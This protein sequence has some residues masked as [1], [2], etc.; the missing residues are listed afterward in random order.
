MADKK[1]M[2]LRAPSRGAKQ[3]DP[4]G[5]PEGREGSIQGIAASSVIRHLVLLGAGCRTPRNGK[6]ILTRWVTSLST[7]PPFR[8]EWRRN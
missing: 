8:W 6:I 3:S 7:Y 4:Q 1:N 5:R 2:S